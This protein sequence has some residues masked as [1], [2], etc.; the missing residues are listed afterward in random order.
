MDGTEHGRWVQF[1]GNATVLIGW[2]GL[3]VM[4]DPNFLHEGQWA[5]LGYGLASRRRVG[6]ALDVS[7]VGR[8]D[9]IVLSH[10]HGDHFDRVARHGLAKDTPIVTTGHAA[11]RLDRWGFGATVGL[12][13]W[14]EETITRG[15]TR[16]RVTS[17]PG[18]HGPRV[19]HRLLPPVMGSI[20]E[21][22]TVGEQDEFRVYVTGDTLVYED[23][24]LIP[25]RY[26]HIDM[27]LLHLGGTKLPGG[28]MVTMNGGQGARMAEL[29]DPEVAVPIHYDDYGVFKSPLR[30]FYD[31]MRARG[32]LERVR[33]LPRGQRVP[34]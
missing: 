32:W 6:P 10:L 16:V 24:E 34:L 3:T 1:V 33:L 7:D 4:T 2:D 9:G 14:Q 21:F 18:R 29:A 28:I 17:V 19:V 15:R 23:I 5:Y 30:H 12:R 13:T 22:G 31:H 8:V 20:L 27:A 25:R 26:P 11:R